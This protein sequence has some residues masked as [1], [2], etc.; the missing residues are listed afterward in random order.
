[1]AIGKKTCRGLHSLGDIEVTKKAF[2]ESEE[3][4][5][6]FLNKLLIGIDLVI[7]VCGFGGGNGTG[8]LPLLVKKINDM[9]IK[10]IS[11]IGKPLLIEGNKRLNL[12][13]NGLE[14]LKKVTNEI[15]VIDSDKVVLS[16]GVSSLIEAFKKVDLEFSNKIIE[17]LKDCE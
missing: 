7:F 3:N 8:L 9:N 4:I 16:S 12:F 13:N 6:D 17:I 2:Y 1:M 11:M 14:E 5:D 15:V 10:S